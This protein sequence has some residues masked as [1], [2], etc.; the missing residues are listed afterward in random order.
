MTDVLDRLRDDLVAAAAR[1]ATQTDPQVVSRRRSHRVMRSK[2]TIACAALVAGS[3]AVAGATEVFAGGEVDRG[4]ASSG[5]T[6]QVEVK[7][8]QPGETC[9][10]VTASD[11]APTRSGGWCGKLRPGVPVVAWTTVGSDLVLYGTTPDSVAT[12]TAGAD[13]VADTQARTQS[14]EGLPAKVFALAIESDQGN[15][16]VTIT[17]RDDAGAV[18][19]RY[20]ERPPRQ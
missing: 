8:G 12:V 4:T 9:M 18:V 1:L 7:P 5:E 11:G 14:R 2:V 19:W 6:Y 15:T 13:G 20:E 10:V 16:P 17:L 3:A